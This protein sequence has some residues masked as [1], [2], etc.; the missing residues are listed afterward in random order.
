MPQP[1]YYHSSASRSQKNN[2][3]QRRLS[4]SDFE[5][6]A[7]KALD[8]TKPNHLTC[9]KVTNQTRAGCP[10]GQVSRAEPALP[11]PPAPG[12]GWHVPKAPRVSQQCDITRPA[13]TGQPAAQAPAAHPGRPVRGRYGRSRAATRRAGAVVAG[14]GWGAITNLCGFAFIPLGRKGWGTCPKFQTGLGQGAPAST[15]SGGKGGT[16]TGRKKEKLKR[17]FR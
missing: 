16:E 11:T 1:T 4:Q 17:G 9:P 6:D 2:N 3:A 10:A 7:H 8:S 13:V 5:K 12:V 15:L 14:W